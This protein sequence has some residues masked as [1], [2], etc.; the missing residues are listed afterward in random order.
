MRAAELHLRASDFYRDAGDRDRAVRHAISAGDLEAA[1]DL[2][3]SSAAPAVSHGE[4]QTVEA[5]LDLFTEAECMGT[6]TL[7]LAVASTQLAAG[8]GHLAEHWTQ[9]ATA[10][11]AASPEMTADARMHAGGARTRR[12]RTHGRRR[13]RRQ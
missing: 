3:W 10:A 5:W 8:Q 6:P 9:A 13:R 4:R 7:A 2:V 1:G 11:S 12:A